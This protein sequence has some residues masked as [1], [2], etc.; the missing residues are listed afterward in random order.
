[1]VNSVCHFD[2]AMR[3]LD[4]WL[5]IVLGVSVRVFELAD[6]RRLTSELVDLS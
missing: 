5:D 4:I 3:C 2:W 1:M 6:S